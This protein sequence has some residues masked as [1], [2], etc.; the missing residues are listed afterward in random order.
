MSERLG[1]AFNCV[2]APDVPALIECCESAKDITRKTFRSHVDTAQL[3]EIE[4]GF[5]YVPHPSQGLT[6]AGDYHVQY[7][8]S[9]YKGRTCYYFVWSAFEY[10]FLP[11][12]GMEEEN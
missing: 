8:R 7:R 12:Q 11:M 4:L 2:G 1:F 10:V 3:R 5:G 6:M 9:K